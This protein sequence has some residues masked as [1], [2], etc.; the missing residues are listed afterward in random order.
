MRT[1]AGGPPARGSPAETCPLRTD[2][3]GPPAGGNINGDFHKYG[4]GIFK[5]DYGK[6]Y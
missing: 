4:D 2:A 6:L 5:N 1:D 3:G